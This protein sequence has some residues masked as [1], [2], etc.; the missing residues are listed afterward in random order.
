ML[1]LS[2]ALGNPRQTLRSVYTSH[3]VR[4]WSLITVAVIVAFGL[5]GFFGGPPLIRHLV[6]TQLSQA[7]HRPVTVGRITLNPYT[8]NLEVDQLRIGEPAVAQTPVPA[9]APASAPAAVPTSGVTAATA[10]APATAVAVPPATVPFFTVEKLV[11]RPS[12][13]ALFRL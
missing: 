1:L 12:W 9:L 11:V 5:L 10:M 2:R 7:L 6:Q 13:S 4:R 8:L 3:A